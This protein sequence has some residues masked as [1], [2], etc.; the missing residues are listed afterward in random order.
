[1]KIQGFEYL[2]IDAAENGFN[3]NLT[4]EIDYYDFNFLWLTFYLVQ[5]ILA[6]YTY[7]YFKCKTT[8]QLAIW[9]YPIEKKF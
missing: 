6:V 2:E 9:N 3:L 1:V 5:V 4:M 8:N 7:K